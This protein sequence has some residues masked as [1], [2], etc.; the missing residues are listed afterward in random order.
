MLSKLGRGG[1]RVAEEVRAAVSAGGAV[2]ALEST[3]FT[4]GMPRPINVDTALEAERIVR[5]RGAVP[6]TVGMLAGRLVVGLSQAEIAALGGD[7]YAIKCST[8]DLPTAMARRLNGGTTVSATLVAARLAGVPVFVTGGI[9]GVHRHGQD[10]MDVSADLVQ[11]GRTPIMTVCAG[12]KAFLDVGRTLEALETQGVGVATLLLGDDA[13]QPGKKEEVEFPAFYTPSSGH[14]SPCT[15][16][17]VAECARVLAG[18]RSLDGPG[19]LLAVPIAREF[20]EFSS[21]VDA[22]IRDALDEAGRL[23][24]RG[25][26]ITPFL[27]D[28]IARLTDGASLRANVALVKRNAD[29]GAQIAKAFSELQDA[30]A[31]TGKNFADAGVSSRAAPRR[32][33]G[34]AVV[35]GGCNLDLTARLK[36]AAATADSGFPTEATHSGRVVI[37]CGGVGRNIADALARCGH[38]PVLLSALGRDQ[39][40]ELHRRLCPHLDWSWVRTAATPRTT[41]PGSDAAND[42]DEA[43]SA[44]YALSLRADGSLLFGVADMDIHGTIDPDYLEASDSA[45]AFD[46]AEIV[47]CD[48]NCPTETVAAARRLARRR[49]AEF[50][51]EP[52]DTHKAAKLLPDWGEKSSEE[53][54]LPLCDWATPN[55]HELAALHR[56][57]S[58]GSA[59]SFD[60]SNLLSVL[61][62]CRRLLAEGVAGSLAVKLGPAG[63]LLVPGQTDRLWAGQGPLHCSAP[64]TP[65]GG[66]V[67]VSG[68][69]DSLVAGLLTARLSGRASLAES[70]IFASL[71]ARAS[72]LGF[73]AVS[74]RLSAAASDSQLWREVTV[75]RLCD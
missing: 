55:L 75:S 1:L 67:S 58:G 68:A 4:S 66:I 22:A 37:T 17:S 20:S 15:L 61:A 74:S 25:R 38:Q 45:G 11:L 56:L 39:A 64:A 42:A 69:G 24:I 19:F 28:R 35:I 49:G 9:G 53:P 59:M 23:G 65:P 3:I 34:R 32:T 18:V 63:L 73:E 40:A 70:G 31:A 12:V 41:T 30:A 62:A 48:A 5:S 46:N 71:C 26:A 16:H 6:A 27:L 10:S 29:V 8:R 52:T 33:S 47:C 51:F 21:T 14:K 2:V 60:S 13:K 54:P 36:D 7:D 50:W 43:R 44:A 72:L 57:V